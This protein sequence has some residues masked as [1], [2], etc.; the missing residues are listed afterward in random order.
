MW[1]CH[2]GPHT[3]CSLGPMPGGVGSHRSVYSCIRS[4]GRNGAAALGSSSALDVVEMFP[5]P[6]SSIWGD[7]WAV[8][9][10]APIYCF[11]EQVCKPLG[12]LL[13]THHARSFMHSLNPQSNNA[14]TPS[15]PQRPRLSPGTITATP[16]P[17]A[18][19][20][21]TPPLVQLN[22]RWLCAP[23]AAAL[24]GLHGL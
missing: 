11:A 2:P 24:E 19:Q 13:E 10:Q 14:R 7:I 16:D 18:I 1:G 9:P 22:L 8:P 17:A 6:S 12:P 3:Y 23:P 5:S 4:R 20:G 21:L 15:S